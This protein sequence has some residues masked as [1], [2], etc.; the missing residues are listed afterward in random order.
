MNNNLIIF[1]KDKSKDVFS[2]APETDEQSALEFFEGMRPEVNK[3]DIEKYFYTTEDEASIDF[4]GS[5]AELTENHKMKINLR[6]L[7]ISKR[8]E[9]IRKKTRRNTR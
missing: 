6:S 1:Y 4:Y 5:Y 3:S 8:V 7:L 2:F 9:E